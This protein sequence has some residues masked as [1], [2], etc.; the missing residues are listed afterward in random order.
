MP[1]I[2]KVLFPVDFSPQC[3][4]AAPFVTSWVGH[5]KAQLTLLHAIAMLPESDVTYGIDVAATLRKQMRESAAA[6]TQAF[7]EQEL[8]S[9]AAGSVIEEGNPAE[10][11]AITPGLKAWT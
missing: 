4:S 5:F 7:A 6:S 9:A 3:R 11:I 2:K 10:I 8:G 1:Q